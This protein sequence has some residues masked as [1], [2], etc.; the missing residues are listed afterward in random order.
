MKIAVVLRMAAF[1]RFVEPILRHLDPADEIVLL[2]PDPARLVKERL[3]PNI[4][5][6][7]S[8]PKVQGRTRRLRDLR[9]CAMHYHW[10][11]HGIMKPE[12]LEH[13]FQHMP[14]HY[15][16]WMRRLHR[17]R[18]S[19]LAAPFFL[20]W[21]RRKERKEKPDLRMRE[22][23]KEI[24]PDV[25]L[26]TP[27][28]YPI[29][30]SAPEIDYIKAARHARIPTVALVASWDNLMTKS[31][32][33]VEPDRVLVWNE[34]QVRELV[35]WHA[36]PREKI[37][38][39]GA[40]VFDQMFGASF[41][42]ERA[43]F[44]RSAGLNPE[45]PYI[46]WLATSRAAKADECQLLHDLLSAMRAYPELKNHQL[47]VRPHPKYVDM[48]DHWSA[49]GAVVWRTPGFPDSDESA[50]GLYNSI[51]HAESVA[52][53]STS[54]FIEAAILDRPCALVLGV[55]QSPKAMHAAFAHFDHLL[56]LGYPEAA[57]DEAGCAR[58][59][60]D[61]ARGLDAG[62][63]RRREFVRVFVRPHGIE[64]PAGACAAQAIRELVPST[65]QS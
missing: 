16:P 47:L 52:G 63:E 4:R 50:R 30:R 56:K 11:S 36:I 49:P 9:D 44:C 57:D 31:L 25:L 34:I 26:A 17:W 18:L 28:V 51:T 37:S 43:A 8:V 15:V 19:W 6:Q 12:F 59:F 46:L 13:A 5:V 54:A 7:E 1:Y 61:I 14:S 23:L 2:L 48:F 41:L 60:A 39:V 21:L 22:Q 20:A 55:K 32:F 10:V 40:P 35:D 64:I 53:L 62:A 42:Q 45:Q 3:L 58:W 24:A 27:V 29:L 33:H 38:M 65:P